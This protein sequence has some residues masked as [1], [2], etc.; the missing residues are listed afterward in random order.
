M[1]ALAILVVQVCVPFI[2]CA[3]KTCV[4]VCMVLRGGHWLTGL[5]SIRWCLSGELCNFPDGLRLNR[6]RKSRTRIGLEQTELPNAVSFFLKG[7][8]FYCAGYGYGYLD[9][10]EV[11][12]LESE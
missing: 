5:V 6:N 12:S 7:S 10:G 11:S 1:G 3:T 4:C 2:L 9:L 8:P